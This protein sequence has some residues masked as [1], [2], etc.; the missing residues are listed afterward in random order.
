MLGKA[1]REKACRLLKRLGVV[2]ALLTLSACAWFGDHIRTDDKDA[3]DFELGETM[4]PDDEETGAGDSD[5]TR[6]DCPQSD[7]EVLVD[8]IHLLIVRQPGGEV[9]LEVPLDAKFMLTFRGDGRI[10]SQGFENRIP[11]WISGTLD[12]CTI[13]G[14][15]T[16]TAEFTGT[17]S[18]GYVE[19]D[20]VEM[21]HDLSTTTTCPGEGSQTIFLEGMFSAPEDHARFE[22]RG[23][24]Y[25][26]V[27]ELD[28]PAQALFYSW[29]FQFG[30]AVAP[31]Y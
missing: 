15:A 29:T 11:L 16:L 10:D 17:C 21:L 1:G 28:I 26:H 13:T 30:S 7:V 9:K 4:P 22:L 19:M 18:N 25:T 2:G 14:E 3:G 6:A 5:S 23:T 12:D 8:Y 27:L 31:I 24:E 20:I